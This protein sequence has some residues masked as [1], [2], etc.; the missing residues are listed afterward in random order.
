MKPASGV[1]GE[2]MAVSVRI[3]DPQPTVLTV[4]E[5]AGSMWV[6]DVERVVRA[7]VPDAVII[8]LACRGG[9]IPRTTS[10]KPRRRELWRRWRNDEFALA[11]ALARDAG[12]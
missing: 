8:T 11:D 6:D 2:R 12:R 1:P 7:E 10:G 3:V 4:L 9:S 5:R